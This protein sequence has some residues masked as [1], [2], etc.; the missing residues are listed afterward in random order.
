MKDIRRL[1]ITSPLT[2]LHILVTLALIPY[3]YL[4]AE[5]QFG[6]PYCYIFSVVQSM[7]LYMSILAMI[8][9]F[10]THPGEVSKLIIDKL[11]H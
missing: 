7:L 1:F 5:E 8:R 9:T 2:L 11:K 4:E 6:T 3:A 10:T